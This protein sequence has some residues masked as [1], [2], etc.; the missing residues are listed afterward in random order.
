MPLHC[1]GLPA[2]L[3]KTSLRS[4]SKVLQKLFEK[5]WTEEK[6]PSEWL[7]GSIIKL[8]KQEQVNRY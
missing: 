5:I 8:S 7:K 1:S 2:E 6:I 3:F 4:N